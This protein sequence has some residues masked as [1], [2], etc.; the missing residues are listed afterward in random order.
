MFTDP[1]EVGTELPDRDPSA[2]CEPQECARVEAGEEIDEA[3]ASVL[4]LFKK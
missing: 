4:E 3:D 2:D 1:D